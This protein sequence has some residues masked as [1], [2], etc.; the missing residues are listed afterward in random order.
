MRVRSV[1]VLSAAAVLSSA[2]GRALESGNTDS[3]TSSTAES[4][5]ATESG[6]EGAGSIIVT[7]NRGPDEWLA[8]FADPV[9]AQAAIDR[10]RGNAYDL[11][12]DGESYRDRQ[13]PS[14]RRDRHPGRKGGR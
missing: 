7:S 4:S 13:K 3:S 11:V 5:T 6:S 10:F 2:C 12:V 14:L 8:T 1:H 9:R